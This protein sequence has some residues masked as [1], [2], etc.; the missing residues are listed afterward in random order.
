[1]GEMT[2]E[3]L[4]LQSTLRPRGQQ[5]RP[6]DYFYN[7]SRAAPLFLPQQTMQ[8]ES[9]VAQFFGFGPAQTPKVCGDASINLGIQS[10]KSGGSPKPFSARIRSGL[11]S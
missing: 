9:K 6:P 8:K 5:P 3:R 4:H 2:A 7:R 11:L 1:M 10:S